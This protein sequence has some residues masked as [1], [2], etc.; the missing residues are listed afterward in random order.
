MRLPHVTKAV[1]LDIVQEPGFH[2]PARVVARCNF[3]GQTYA[4]CFRVYPDAPDAYARRHL[5]EL[6]L[7]VGRHVIFGG[8]Q[9]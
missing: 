7:H 3:Q 9:S 6:A 8:A 4:Q 1:T 5:D 2:A